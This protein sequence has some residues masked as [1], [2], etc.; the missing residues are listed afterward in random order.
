MKVIIILFISLIVAV[1]FFFGLKTYQG[2]KNIQLIDSY[3]EE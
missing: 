2:H 1:A 3:L